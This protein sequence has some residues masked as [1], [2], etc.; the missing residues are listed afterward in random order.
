MIIWFEI[1]YVKKYWI[2]LYKTI[3]LSYLNSN[4]IVTLKL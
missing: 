4:L 1:T 3:F 2:K